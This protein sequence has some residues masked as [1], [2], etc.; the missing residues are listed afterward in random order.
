MDLV[1]IAGGKGTR[2]RK[3]SKKPKVLSNF[4]KI[5]LI[6]LYFKIY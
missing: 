2:F 3:F 4:G 5:N 1:I 6:D